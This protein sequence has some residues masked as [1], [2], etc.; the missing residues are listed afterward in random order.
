MFDKLAATEQQYDELVHLL[1]TAEIQ[2]DQ[3]EYRKHAKAAAELE[4]L[5][6]RYREYK[7]V[8]HDL[9]QTEELARSADPDLR[10]LAQEELKSLVVR[11]DGRRAARGRRGRHSGQREGSAGRHLLLERTGGTERQHHVLGRAP[12]AHPHRP[13]GLATGREVTGQESREGDEGPPLPA[14]RDGAP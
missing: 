9:A 14:L 13:R 10:D 11:R 2:S 4:T 6:E 1:G 12:H 8:A 7:A 3:A 5:V